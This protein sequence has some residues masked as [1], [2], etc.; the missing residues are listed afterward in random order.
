MLNTIPPVVSNLL[1]SPALSLWKT[2]TKSRFRRS[3]LAVFGL[4]SITVLLIRR[5][6]GASTTGVSSD[7]DVE[8]F[9]ENQE[10]MLGRVREIW[11]EYCA[12]VGN[13]SV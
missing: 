4:L 3:G 7:P 1:P 6:N 2:L 11:D 10:A 8:D 5:R 13:R 9:T 12:G